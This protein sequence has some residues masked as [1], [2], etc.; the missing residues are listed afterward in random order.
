LLE[1]LAEL[2]GEYPALRALVIGDALSSDHDDSARAIQR[3]AADL[4][5]GASVIFTGLRADVPRLLA[6][7]DLY[8]LPSWREGMPRSILE[9]MA[10]SLPVVA[11]DIRGCREEVID[12]QTGLIVP[13]RDARA[14][15]GALG[16]LLRDDQKRRR[17]GE[18]GRRR[19]EQYFSEA[20][21]IERQMRVLRRLFLEKNLAWPRPRPAAATAREQ[22]DNEKL[23]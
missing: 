5:L 18:A 21:V 2:R 17:M 4:G 1:A 23:T 14:L 11:T 9:A 19:A 7:G 12:G 15:A 10:A 22:E 8:C 6:L 3:A 13:V 16:G 20:Q